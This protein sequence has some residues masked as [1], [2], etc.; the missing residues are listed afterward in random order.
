MRFVSRHGF[1]LKVVAHPDLIDPK[2]RI[3]IRAGRAPAMTG[4]QERVGQ[5]LPKRRQ[6][7]I[8]RRSIEVATDDQVVSFRNALNMSH[9]LGNLLSMLDPFI[10]MVAPEAGH[11]EID[12]RHRWSQPDTDNVNQNTTRQFN[13]SMNEVR[14]RIRERRPNLS[15][16][17]NRNIATAQKIPVLPEQ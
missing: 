16:S 4:G 14:L 13:F 11:P 8:N 1:P 10:A 3:L 15:V 5:S 6:R 12:T 17:Q 2:Q 9:Q 7:V